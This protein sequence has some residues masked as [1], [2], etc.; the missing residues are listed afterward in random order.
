MRLWPVEHFFPHSPDQC[1]SVLL[2]KKM[3]L[4][5]Y[6]FIRN[7]HPCSFLETFTLT[8]LLDTYSPLLLYHISRKIPAYS[9]IRAYLFIR[10][11]RVYNTLATICTLKRS[12]RQSRVPISWSCKS[13]NKLIILQCQKQFGFI[14][15][16]HSHEV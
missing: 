11:L 8:R 3:K 14:V 4:K 16:K 9:L 10:E 13:I 5:P 6:S 1:W 15:S 2:W 7:I 12:Y